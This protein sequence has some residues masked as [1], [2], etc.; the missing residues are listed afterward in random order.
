M[1][2]FV[3]YFYKFSIKSFRLLTIRIKALFCRFEI[4]NHCI[5]LA[6]FFYHRGRG[7][8]Q[9][10]S[11]GI[12]I[13]GV[14]KVWNWGVP[15][16]SNIG[17]RIYLYSRV[18]KILRCAHEFSL[19]VAQMVELFSLHWTN[20][21]EISTVYFNLPKKLTLLSRLEN[22]KKFTFCLQHMGGAHLSFLYFTSPPLVWNFQII[23][24]RC[25][26]TVFMH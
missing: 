24:I 14:L 9:F 21:S 7:S 4:L 1:W 19:L 11:F 26:S 12:F 10:K 17:R 23:Q 13:F 2:C 20:W 25:R 22:L 15:N 16:F 8:G 6:F 18:A 5:I 3:G